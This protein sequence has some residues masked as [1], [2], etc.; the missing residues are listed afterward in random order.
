MALRHTLT[1]SVS[2]MDGS[3]SM[4]LAADGEISFRSAGSHR[5]EEGE[6]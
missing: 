6:A 3:R 1:V 4:V 2:D 5:L